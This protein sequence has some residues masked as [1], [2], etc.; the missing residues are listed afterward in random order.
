MS[1]FEPRIEL[2]EGIVDVVYA[3]LPLTNDIPG[4]KWIEHLV[5]VCFVGA[6]YYVSWKE[7]KLGTDDRFGYKNQKR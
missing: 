1:I 7:F 3:D 5:V 2:P 6:F 4:P